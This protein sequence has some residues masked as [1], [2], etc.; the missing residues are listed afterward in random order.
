MI[1]VSTANNKIKKSPNQEN[2]GKDSRRSRKMI[3]S[4]IDYPDSVHTANKKIKKSDNQENQ[5]KDKCGG[6]M[7]SII[8]TQT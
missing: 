1:Q 5:G 8:S 2:Q 6:R 4:I 7:V 3:V